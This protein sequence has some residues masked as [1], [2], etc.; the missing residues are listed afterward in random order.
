MLTVLTFPL[1]LAAL[2]LFFFT[3]GGGFLVLPLNFIG[4]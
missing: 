4:G 1:K 3:I 2:G